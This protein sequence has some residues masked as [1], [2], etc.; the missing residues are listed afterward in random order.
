MTSLGGAGAQ[1]GAAIGEGAAPAGREQSGRRQAPSKCPMTPP[2][3][4]RRA[5]TPTFRRTRGSG[6]RV[7]NRR[8]IR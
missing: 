6:R 4:G 2:Y 5:R 1:R 8:P 7:E 3:P